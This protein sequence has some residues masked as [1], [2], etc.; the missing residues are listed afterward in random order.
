[1]RRSACKAAA[2]G[3]IC[4]VVMAAMVAG[5]A[6]AL[7]DGR[8]Y[9]LVSPPGKNGADVTALS[10]KAHV[11][12]DGARVTYTALG[13]FGDVPGTSVD[14]QYLSRRDG[15]AGTSG[16]ST[17]G[18]GPRQEGSTYDAVALGNHP[19]FEA[20]FTP[21]LASAI[22]RSW[23]PLTDSENEEGVA[24]LYR[25]DDLAVSSP[26][27]TLLT[28]AATPLADL[29]P[30]LFRM[31]LINA[32]AGASADLRHVLFE[33]PWNLVGDGSFNFAPSLYEHAEGVGVRLVGWIPDGTD[34][35]CDDVS[36]PRCVAAATSQAGLSATSF[37]YSER[38]MSA[39]GER[40]AFQVPGGSVSGAVYMRIGGTRTVQINA[41]EKA[42][43]ES[44]GTAQIW[45]MATDGS[46]V[47][48]TTSEGLVDGDDGGESDLYMYEPDASAG[49]R[50]TRLSVSET[51]DPHSVHSVIG[52]S[53]DGRYVYFASGGQLV[54]GEPAVDA[55]GL[56]VWH[57]GELAFIG[58]FADVNSVLINTPLTQ[59]NFGIRI[60]TARITPDGRHLL[61]ML[62]TDEGFRGRGGFAGFEHGSSCSFEGPACRELY[63][64]SAD[65]GRLVC[66]TC[67]QLTGV[68]GG[69]AITDPQV[70]AAVSI[71]TQHLSNALTADGRRVFFSSSD[72]L[73][74]EDTNGK[75]DAY[76]YDVAT[77]TVHLLSSG[78]STAD[79]Y[80]IEASATGDDVF[81][82]TR[83][84]LLGWDVDDNYDLYDA[85]VGGGFP[86]PVA[87][88]P[89]CTG[90]TCRAAF[91][92]QPAGKA[93]ASSPYRGKGDASGRLRRHRRCRG[94]AVLRRVRGKRKC[95][96]RRA[97]RRVRRSARSERS[98]K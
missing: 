84:R 61:F 23:R 58:R 59:W 90:D 37:F 52:A 48:F 47:F 32:F 83:E 19:T 28:S 29:D 5:A 33:S 94:R 10:A 41:S 55:V 39:D 66:A 30:A 3:A 87:A 72:A 44:P 92:P 64:Y 20:A 36:G 80:F 77:G 53:D 89:V 71:T 42:S 24:N 49:E 81:F 75:W 69:D 76:E 9:E 34:V 13:A 2:G 35:A 56:Y 4:L 17:R 12:T 82:V 6:A 91:A 79:S 14:V 31:F 73:V 70:G 16:W 11:A 38:M 95:V 8:R 97:H 93:P 43:P 21:D 26:L 60:R 1:M 7:P 51:A 88:A 65:S 62:N 54:D 96:K 86:E 46:R 98:G 22:Y 15:S 25:L 68:A 45:D 27:A 50:L 67:N 18:I 40:I 57:D 78:K 63:L 74:T 85:R